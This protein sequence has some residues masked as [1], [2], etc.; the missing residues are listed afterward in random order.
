M[1][2]LKELRVSADPHEDAPEAVLSPEGEQ[3]LREREAQAIRGLQTAYRRLREEIAKV[4]IGQQ[5]IVDQ[6][7]ISLFSKGHC[8]L[9]GVP[10]LAKTLLVSTV[11]QVL[12][13]SYRRIQFTP[14]LMLSLIHI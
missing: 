8:L 13:L 14:D 4:I 3:E 9:I 2:Q 12:H 6:L 7:L 10:G 1:S 11:S 5:D